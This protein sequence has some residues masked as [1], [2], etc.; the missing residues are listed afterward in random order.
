MLGGAFDADLWQGLV[1]QVADTEPTVRHGV[2]A[3][4]N[5][6]R[7]HGVSDGMSECVCPRCRQALRHYNKAISSF[8]EYMQRPPDRQAIDVALLSCL[9][10]I[11]IESYRLNDKTAISLI[12]K[13]CGM[14]VEARPRAQETQTIAVDSVLRNQFDRLWLLSSMFG[15]HIPR[16]SQR[17]APS[18]LTAAELPITGTVQTAR[19]RLHGIIIL[20]QSL[21]LRVFRAQ[22]KPM[23]V[24]EW[25]ATITALQEEQQTVLLLLESWHSD[26]QGLIDRQG[27]HSF[28]NSQAWSILT[29][30]WLIT[31]IRAGASTDPSK[32]DSEDQSEDY[33]NLVAVAEESLMQHSQDCEA[34]NFSFEPGFLPALYLTARKCRDSLIRRKALELMSLAGGKEGLWYRSE[35][36]CIAARVIAL[37]EGLAVLDSQDQLGSVDQKPVRFYDIL[38]DLNYRHGGRTYVNVTYLMYDAD[39]DSRWR[40]ARETLTITD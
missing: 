7:H 10:F 18:I 25:S 29:V 13:G 37:E 28:R 11:C 27:L 38:A 35:L 4:G 16:P 1:M 30:H 39:S 6:F 32:T 31:K 33:R 5:L 12:S 24:S 3:L 19:D 26:L 15:H 23:A 40:T 21:R 20:V 2:F 9:I 14:I 22:M 34:N 17:P 8:A 36:R